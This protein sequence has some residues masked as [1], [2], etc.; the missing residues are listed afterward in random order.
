MRHTDAID[1][2][3]A[4]SLRA[5][6]LMELGWSEL[7]IPDH[8]GVYRIHALTR[9]GKARRISRC[10]GVDDTGTL[11]VG[12]SRNLR[13]QVLR[14]AESASGRRPLRHSAGGEYYSSKFWKRFPLERLGCE[15]LSP[16]SEAEARLRKRNYQRL[17]RKIFL[18]NPPL[19]AGIGA[20][21]L[22][23]PAAPPE[24]PGSRFR[25]HEREDA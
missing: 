20:N 19:D 13:V 25:A 21:T 4:A 14:F 18:D 3:V 7:R 17:Y 22:S 15:F 23:E 11:H 8:C 16:L 12:E 6:G 24:V 9:S 10:N 2:K 5:A 1:P